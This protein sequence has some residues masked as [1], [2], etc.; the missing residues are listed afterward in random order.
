MPG[1]ESI[2]ANGL[3]GQSSELTQGSQPASGFRMAFVVG[4]FFSFR[5]ALVMVCVR[6][7]GV[8][9]STGAAAGV[10]ADFLLLAAVCFH[11]FA[12][13][14]GMSDRTSA[15]V[16]CFP[17]IRWVYAYL[18]F[19]LLSLAWS[20]TVSPL[21]SFAYWCGVAADVAIVV[22][23]LQAAPA[24]T[25]AH[26]LMKGF[27]WSSCLLALLAWLMPV[28]PDLRLG[29]PDYFNTNQL[30]NLCAFAIFMTQYLMRRG[31]GK[32]RLASV[33]LFIT[34]IRSLS[35]STIA[36][37]LIAQAVLLIQDRS[38]SRR[39]KT[40]LIV[41]VAALALAF[42]GLFEAYFDV[43]TSAGNQAETLTGRLAIWAWCFDGAMQKPWLGN[44][45]DSLWKVVPPFGPDAFE[46][47]HA[48]NELLQEFYAFGVA[49]VVLLCGIYGSLWRQILKLGR[50]SLRAVFASLMVFIVIRGFAVAE[51]FDLLLPLWTVVV[52]GELAHRESTHCESIAGCGKEV[53][54]P[55]LRP[56]APGEALTARP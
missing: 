22:V 17:G 48:E 30:A 24:I 9:P 55:A 6:L 49:G 39:T 41:G 37:F 56:S 23:L 36:A 31:D 3:A 13:S 21:V 34:L 29:D 53:S 10:L 12:G 33:F 44:G 2:P 46:P 47:R 35:K 38:M 18:A 43:Y 7:L 5:I 40:L 14:P 20:A 15:S 26:A 25:T 32:W 28:Q 1:T 50:S 42:W 51:A 4:F 11:S 52:V 8:E 16:L 27:I 54:T 19:S 45:F